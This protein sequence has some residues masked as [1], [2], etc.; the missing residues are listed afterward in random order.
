MNPS[1]SI[2]L[3]KSRPFCVNSVDICS[4]VRINRGHLGYILPVHK[5]VAPNPWAKRISKVGCQS[6]IT[7]GRFIDL[8]LTYFAVVLRKDIPSQ[9]YKTRN[10]TKL[11][12]KHLIRSESDI[13][14]LVITNKQ[15]RYFK[16]DIEMCYLRWIYDFNYKIHV[17]IW[18]I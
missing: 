3:L 10:L 15:L 6:P 2:E 5:A 13:S 16:I 14:E 4:V 11:S 18:L 12:Q 17:T 8:I 9:I 7:R 1:G